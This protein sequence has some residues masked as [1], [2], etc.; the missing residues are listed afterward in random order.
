[1][2]RAAALCGDARAYRARSTNVIL[3]RPL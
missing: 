2:C 3:V 1:L